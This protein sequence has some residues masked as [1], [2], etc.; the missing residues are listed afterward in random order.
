MDIT[1]ISLIGAFSGFFITHILQKTKINKNTILYLDP[2][3]SVIF[4]CFILWLFKDKHPPIFK[5]YIIVS[6][7]SIFN[8]LII[9]GDELKSNNPLLNTIFKGIKKEEVMCKCKFEEQKTTCAI[10][11]KLES[12]DCYCESCHHIKSE[13]KCSKSNCLCKNCKCDKFKGE[14]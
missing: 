6:F 3:L 1:E 13:C 2:I 12:C 11:G 10:C 5:E 9:D 7:C 8:N 4:A 14:K